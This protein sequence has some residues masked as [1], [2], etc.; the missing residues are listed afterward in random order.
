MTRINLGL[1]D[2]DRARIDL[3]R[4]T[5]ARQCEANE[6]SII[7]ADAARSLSDAMVIPMALAVAADT[8]T[9]AAR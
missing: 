7:T 3:V 5:F 4:E 2:E 1:S 8:I 9:G 6:Y